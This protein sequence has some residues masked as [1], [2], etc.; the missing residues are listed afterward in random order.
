MVLFLATCSL[1]KAGGG[2]RVYDEGATIASVLS[3]GLKDRLLERREAVR[4][5]VKGDKSLLWQGMPLPQLELNS[6]LTKGPDFGGRRDAAYLPAIHRYDGRFL[7][8]TGPEGRKKL[9]ESRHQTLFL[10][11]LYGLVRPS[12]PIQLYSCPLLHQIAER[13]ASDGLLTEVLC[14]YLERRDVAKVF[15]LTAIDAYRR[16]IDWERVRPRVEVLHCFAATGAGAD[17]LVPFGRVLGSDLLD[18]TEDGLVAVRTDTEVGGVGF[19]RLDRPPSGYPSEVEEILAAGDEAEILQDLP[20]ESLTEEYLRGGN[21]DA[22][23]SGDGNGAWRFKATSK[24]IKDMNAIVRLFDRVIEALTVMREGPTTAHGNT[25]K[26][27]T[28]ELKGKW[29]Y[30]IGDYRL[31]YEP[32]SERQ[33]VKLLGISHRKDVY[34]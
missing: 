24:F 9:A 26:P 25:V 21:P 2:E 10:S 13:W 5:L 11:G 22:V 3:P 20:L 28:R 33:V 1:N 12:E 17:A 14:D 7:L 34:D 27:L 16:L 29:R 30:R 4:Q 8:A 31:V 6:G 23:A 19:R 32:D 15:D 18:R